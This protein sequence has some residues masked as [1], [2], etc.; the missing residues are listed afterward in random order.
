MSRTQVCRVGAGGGTRTWS[1]REQPH[2]PV[3]QMVLPLWSRKNRALRSDEGRTRGWACLRYVRLVGSLFSPVPAGPL[4]NVPAFPA[5]AVAESVHRM[6]SCAGA[7]TWGVLALL[8][9]FPALPSHRNASNVLVFYRDDGVSRFIRIPLL[10]GVVRTKDL[11]QASRCG[12]FAWRAKYIYVCSEQ[13]VAEVVAQAWVV[14]GCA[15]AG[16]CVV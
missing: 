13:A 11:T 4:V 14:R 15:R 9:W 5:V 2:L 16:Q 10:H 1:R 6:S 3:S 7:E 12:R 8:W